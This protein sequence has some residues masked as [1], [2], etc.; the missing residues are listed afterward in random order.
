MVE[1]TAVYGIDSIRY[2]SK[3]KIVVSKGAPFY[4][5]LGCFISLEMNQGIYESVVVKM[6]EFHIF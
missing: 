1:N 6:Y 2:Q 4:S 5:E 3:E